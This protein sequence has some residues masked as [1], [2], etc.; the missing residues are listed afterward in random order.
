M[1]SNGCLTVIPKKSFK[2]Y[3]DNISRD[4]S[5]LNEPEQKFT[6]K[7]LTSFQL[8]VW[9]VRVSDPITLPLR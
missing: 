8:S 5:F 2:S 1:D 6:E 4:G 7:L 3:P 9:K